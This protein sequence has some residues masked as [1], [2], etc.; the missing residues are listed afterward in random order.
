MPVKYAGPKLD[1]TGEVQA[2]GGLLEFDETPTRVPVGPPPT[3]K[4]DTKAVPTPAPADLG[5]DLDEE[6]KKKKE[7]PR[8]PTPVPPRNLDDLDMEGPATIPIRPP[9]PDGKIPGADEVPP[10]TAAEPSGK[11]TA[12]LSDDGVAPAGKPAGKA[13]PKLASR[14][15]TKGEKADKEAADKKAAQ[16]P[17]ITAAAEQVSSTLGAIADSAK[18]AGTLAT[19]VVTAPVVY[20]V[21]GVAWGLGK[22]ASMAVEGFNIAS[23]GAAWGSTIVGMAASAVGME[24]VGDKMQEAGEATR[25]NVR[26]RRETMKDL[27]QKMNDFV[28]KNT[29]GNIGDLIGAVSNGFEPK[30]HIDPKEVAKG[31]ADALGV[32]V[33]LD[34]GITPETPFGVRNTQYSQLAVSITADGQ[35]TK[36]GQGSLVLDINHD[37]TNGPSIA[38]GMKD[39][40]EKAGVGSQAV[41]KFDPETNKVIVT[42]D[43]LPLKDQESREENLSSRL[44]K[45]ADILGL[46]DKDTVK[47]AA[48]E[49]MARPK[50][51]RQ[52]DPG[53]G[54]EPVEREKGFMERAAETM[55]TKKGILIGL[56]AAMA[57]GVGIATGGVG[58]AVVAGLATAGTL[59]TVDAILEKTDGKDV[60]LGGLANSLKEPFQPATSLE[61][62]K[63]RTQEGAKGIAAMSAE[64]EKEITATPTREMQAE[65]GRES[66][67]KT[68]D[69]AKALGSD[70]PPLAGLEAKAVG[71]TLAPG[72]VKGGPSTG[73][74]T[75]VKASLGRTG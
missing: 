51:D 71:G 72:E 2:P 11:D 74:T 27:N 63:G 37:H 69:L 70:A 3:P 60:F 31:R 32:E 16:S 30:P 12:D 25:Q 65:R 24:G 53:Q 23:M 58:L 34:K 73:G 9:G 44:G 67:A 47:A 6:D 56:G 26:D 14:R 29:V 10:G 38:A 62:E 46:A 20:P 57:V 35:E 41:V 55:F 21:K 54:L 48:K 43:S 50:E 45:V 19:E 5:A 22:V 33:T 68:A 18:A 15:E 4:P 13:G 17:G 59:G 66:G 61:A 39:R 28:S 49:E 42:V 36:K 7:A 40:L 1:E 64:K 8:M 52:L 75:P